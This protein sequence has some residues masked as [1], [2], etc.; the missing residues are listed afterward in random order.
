MA[1]NLTPTPGTW[2]WAENADGTPIALMAS[3]G[4]RYVATPQANMGD[5]YVDVSEA[6]AKLIEAAPD[7]LDV[8]RVIAAGG[9]DIET[10]R[11]LARLAVR[12]FEAATP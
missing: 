5:H 4:G 9:C 11:M 7:H 8:L 1:G 2:F 6:D 10:A 12:R 3:P